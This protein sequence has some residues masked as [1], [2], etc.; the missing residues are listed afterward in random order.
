MRL[1]DL[2]ARAFVQGAS[3]TDEVARGLAKSVRSMYTDASRW[4]I[5]P[6]VVPCLER[7][8]AQGW[9]HFVL[10]NHVPELEKLISQ[11]GLAC[12]F[13]AVYCS[14][15]TGV[16]KPHPLA[17]RMLQEVVTDASELWMIGDSWQADICGAIQAGIKAILVRKPNPEA[18][19][20]CPDLS[21]LPSML[22][23]ALK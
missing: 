19:H 1:E 3:V 15:V 14:A 21:E 23:T 16:E 8:S 11:L 20:F 13:N 4:R 17:F 12:H 5:Y 2:F 10:S 9:E 7:L 22:A 18:K 6:D